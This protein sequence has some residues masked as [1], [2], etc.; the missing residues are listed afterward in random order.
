MT[1][2]Q[3]RALRILLVTNYFPPEV[4]APAI[5]GFEHARLWA[6]A[7]HEVEVLTAVP[8]FPEGR[9][10]D[11]YRNRLTR[12]ERDG[13][14]T[15]RVPVVLAA[16]RGTG[17]R[18]L[19][20]VSFLV[21][22]VVGARRLS[23]RPD[24]VIATSPQL[25]A[26]LAGYRIARRLA[27][28]FILEVRDLWPDSIVAV[29]ALPDA[30]PVRL[31]ARL[32][33]F[34][35]AGAS[36]VVVVTEPFRARL[37]ERGVPASK[38]SVLTNGVDAG[39]LPLVTSEER[40]AVR[41]GLGLDESFIV[42]WVGT[43]GLAHG[44]EVLI[45]AARQLASERVAFVVAGAGAD[46]DRVAKAARGLSNVRLLG[47]LPRHDALRLLASSD[48]AVVHLRRSPV[49]RDVIPTRMLEAMALG[50]PVLIGVEG[51]ARRLAELSGAGVAFE[52]ECAE[53]LLAALDQVVRDA[54]LRQRLGNA[55]P[56]FVHRHFDRRVIASEY[57]D[58]LGA[59]VGAAR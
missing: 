24:V 54:D 35:Y 38:V 12:E 13:I 14:R 2:Q 34:L 55:G 9:I 16:N 47:R 40:A 46:A 21:S 10:H 43:L 5:R 52:P 51:E 20:Y 53:S 26:G 45:E 18:S 11:G 23:S 6:A 3:G 33:R 15:L 17:R 4:N 36:H 25:L 28:P 22:S 56:P 41:R 8:N 1:L 29:G 42:A 37:Q 32:E 50:R 7:G 58:L 39:S 48:A 27:V 44:A 57:L 59:V 30:L 31:L 49:F 19:A